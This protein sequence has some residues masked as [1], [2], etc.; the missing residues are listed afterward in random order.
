MQL[1]IMY[2]VERTI[3]SLTLFEILI[4][5][6][7]SIDLILIFVVLSVFCQIKLMTSCNSHIKINDD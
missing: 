1:R 4:E 6:V 3:M 2:M 5:I 7:N